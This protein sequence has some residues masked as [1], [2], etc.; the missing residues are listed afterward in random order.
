MFRNPKVNLI[1]IFDQKI[2]TQGTLSLQGFRWASS[3]V[4][5]HGLSKG[6]N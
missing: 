1:L 2:V 5:A 4:F 3:S 6:E